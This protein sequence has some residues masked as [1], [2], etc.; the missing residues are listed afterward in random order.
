MS[1]LIT[2]FCDRARP[3]RVPD[4]VLAL[5]APNRLATILWQGRRL[6]FVTDSGGDPAC[7]FTEATVAGLESLIGHRGFQ[8]W[9]LVFDR[10]SVYDA[11]GGPVWYARQAEYNALP[12]LGSRVQSWSVGLDA[13]S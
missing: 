3:Q 12:A 5:T 6:A 7:C 13:G 9:A 4:D 1:A 11:G 2:H 8:P 10:Q